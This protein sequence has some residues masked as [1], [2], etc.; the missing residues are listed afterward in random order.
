MGEA[1]GGAHADGP[2]GNLVHPGGS[3]PFG[4][5]RT[6]NVVPTGTSYSVPSSATPV[7][8]IGPTVVTTRCTGVGATTETVQLV[9]VA[10][11]VVVVDGGLI[12]RT[13]PLRR[14]ASSV[15]TTP[16]AMAR[17]ISTPNTAPTL[18][19]PRRRAHGLRPLS[20]SRTSAYCSIS[21]SR[22]EYPIGSYGRG[23]MPHSSANVGGSRRSRSALI[24]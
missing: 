5:S 11:S 24:K 18:R 3:T 2:H 14:E 9:V 4:T 7:A 23:A 20:H 12:G 8:T 6:W 22:G 19:D 13:A 1:S 17:T 16:N 10:T 15:P 21:R